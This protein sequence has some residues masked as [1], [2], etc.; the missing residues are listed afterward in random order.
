M[1]VEAAVS[2][3]ET[4]GVVAK[5]NDAAEM[6]GGNF[7]RVRV[8]VDIMKPL[9]SGKMITWDQDREGWVSFMYERLPNIYYWCGRLSHNNKD[10]DVWL[11]SK[12]ELKEEEQQYG[13]WLKAP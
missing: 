9:C 6:K 12:G 5:K 10:C 11:G 1:T 13:P 4:L 3:G 8:A 2:L 7:I